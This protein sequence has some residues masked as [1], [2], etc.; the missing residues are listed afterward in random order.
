MTDCPR[1]RGQLGPRV[2]YLFPAHVHVLTTTTTIVLLYLS[3]KAMCLCVRPASLRAMSAVTRAH[4]IVLPSNDSMLLGHRSSLSCPG[5]FGSSGQRMR[6]AKRTCFRIDGSRGRP[7]VMRARRVG[8]RILK[9]RFGISTCHGGPRMGAALLANS[10]T[11]DGG[12]GS[13]HVVLGPGR[14][15][16]CGGI[17]GGLAH[18]IAGGTGSRVS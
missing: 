6:L 2:Q 11:I 9:A 5:Q 10:M 1:L 12:D 4:G 14:V 3:M 15:T 8:M 16:M 17:K 18:R 13:I 7:F